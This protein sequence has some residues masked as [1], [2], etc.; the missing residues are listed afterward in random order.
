MFKQDKTHTLTQNPDKNM[1]TFVNLYSNLTF[2]IK[3]FC[4]NIKLW[5]FWDVRKSWSGENL[6]YF[7][8][9]EKGDYSIFVANF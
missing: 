8:V 5:G 4:Q 3:S 9:V 1:V 2:F 6:N 7:E